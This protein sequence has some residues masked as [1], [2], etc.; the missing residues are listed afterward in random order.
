[1][2]WGFAKIR[3]AKKFA[4]EKKKAEESKPAPVVT[5]YRHV[6]KH[7]ATDA[8]HGAHIHKSVEDKQRIYAE[9][10]R[11]RTMINYS[12]TNSATGTPALTRNSSY[13]N[14]Y[15]WT[16]RGDMSLK[17]GL[18]RNQSSGVVSGRASRRKRFRAVE[19]SPSGHG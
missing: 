5:P 14:G 16:E 6:P 15:G 7:A 17:P 19:F 1:M 9:S 18:R 4:E 11:R 3:N 12:R 10:S 8:L 13:Q 2:T